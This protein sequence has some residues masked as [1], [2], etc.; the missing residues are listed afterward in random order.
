MDSFM[1]KINNG[2]DPN[3]IPG[4]ASGLGY[5]MRRGIRGGSGNHD[6][7]FGNAEERVMV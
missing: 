2:Y 1:R 3:L 6:D 4:Y 5:I 7:L